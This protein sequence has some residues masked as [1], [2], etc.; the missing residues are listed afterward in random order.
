MAEQVITE[1]METVPDAMTVRRT[2]LPEPTAERP[3]DLAK[4]TFEANRPDQLW[5][6][7]PTYVRTWSGWAYVAFVP[8]VYS[9]VIGGRQ[10][11]THMRTDLPLERTTRGHRRGSLGRLRRRRL[12]QRDGRSS[13]RY[14]QD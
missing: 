5:A 3:P 11:A 4:G 10:L 13:Q 1:S 2:T 9:G 8:D 12:R 6:D 7:D 14:F